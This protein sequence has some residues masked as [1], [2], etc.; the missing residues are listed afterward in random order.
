[1][2]P[3]APEPRVRVLFVCLGNI[4]R[5][6]TAHGILQRLVDTSGLSQHIHIDSAGTGDWHIG[7][8]PDQRTAAAALL[9]GYDLSPLRAR[10]VAADDFERFDFILAMDLQ[11]LRDLQQLRP[12]NFRGE[13]S[14]F[15]NYGGSAEREVPDPY[16]GDGA[17]FERVLDLV[18]DAA[19]G[20]LQALVVRY[21]LPQVRH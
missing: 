17:G 19:E 4:C 15:L 1:M 18:E 12:Q 13:L 11:N 6:P 14:L 3:Q 20:L 2:S 10:Q 21:K 7:K 8:G 16:Y 5:S 9:R